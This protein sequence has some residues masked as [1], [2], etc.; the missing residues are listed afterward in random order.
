M[1]SLS[2]ATVLDYLQ[3]YRGGDDGIDFR[4]AVVVVTIVFLLGTGMLRHL[5][6][7]AL[8]GAPWCAGNHPVYRAAEQSGQERS[9]HPNAGR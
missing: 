4:E 3:T 8:D 6:V 1:Q 9:L 5:L 2:D 7:S